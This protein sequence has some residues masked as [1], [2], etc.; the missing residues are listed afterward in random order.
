MVSL[1]PLYQ[2]GTTHE[3]RGMWY[4]CHVEKMAVK[5]FDMNRNGTNK[6]CSRHYRINHLTTSITVDIERPD[7]GNVL[8]S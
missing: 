8:I 3:K 6:K 5:I 1:T 4:V 2:I 7:V